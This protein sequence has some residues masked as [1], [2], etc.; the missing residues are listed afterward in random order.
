MVSHHLVLAA[1]TCSIS[2]HTCPFLNERLSRRK[3]TSACD[4]SVRLLF[5]PI[6]HDNLSGFYDVKSGKDIILAHRHLGDG[7]QAELML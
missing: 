4:L 3:S 5:Q 6:F 7:V 2:S 1:S